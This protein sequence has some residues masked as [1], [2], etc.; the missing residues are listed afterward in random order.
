MA[1]R[2]PYG[3]G[4]AK[5]EEILNAALALLSR[6]GYDRTTVA[7]LA[8]QVGLSQT[9][10]LHYFGSKD[11]LF[12]AVLRHQDEIRSR[13]VQ[14]LRASRRGP[15]MEGPTAAELI[16]ETVRHSATVPGLV[17]LMACFSAAASDPAHPA[18]DF[19]RD[20]YETSLAGGTEAIR[21][22]QHRGRLPGH[23]DPD[24]VSVMVNALVT[25]LQI[26]W[27]HDP[28]VDMADHVAYFWELITSA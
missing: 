18:H 8:H 6:E 14:Q 19:F 5:R 21:G 1:Q 12:T 3:K 23:L 4:V 9:G 28:D 10:L 24:R 25:G 13:E 11:E 22:M 26:H 16:V 17:Q 15:E 20:R 27:M 7:E 2:G